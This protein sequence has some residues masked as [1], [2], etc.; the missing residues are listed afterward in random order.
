MLR[1]TMKPL[2]AFTLCVAFSQAFGACDKKETAGAPGTPQGADATGAAPAP[3]SAALTEKGKIEALIAHLET[4]ADAKFIRN[5]S[6]YDAAMAARFL[7]G[8]W[9]AKE[10]EIKTAKD[11]IA[12]SA[13]ASSSGKPYLIRFKDG[14]ENACSDYLTEQLKKM[15]NPTGR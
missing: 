10:D 3:G 2:L 7:R 12:K 6:D 13:T 1:G 14:T 9:N 8:K 11:F 4:L 5:G 15:E